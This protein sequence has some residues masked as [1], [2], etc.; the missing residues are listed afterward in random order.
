MVKK[1]EKAEIIDIV[2]TETVDTTEE[3]T[4]K[5]KKPKWSLK[6]KL[7]IGGGVLVGLIFGA[8]A[9]GIKK[10]EIVECQLEDSNDDDEEIE[11]EVVDLEEVPENVTESDISET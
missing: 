8:C 10:E 7:L 3:T 4:T 9:L 11:D 2:D 5:A 1:V 6:K